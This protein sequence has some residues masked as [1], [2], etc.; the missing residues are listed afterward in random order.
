[1]SLNFVMWE[2]EKGV[3]VKGIVRAWGLWEVVH[4][5]G[6]RQSGLLMGDPLN[7]TTIFIYPPPPQFLRF[8]KYVSKLN[9]VVPCIAAQHQYSVSTLNGV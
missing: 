8:E 9:G 4:R 5:T 2:S 3:L 7:V 1:M 6:L